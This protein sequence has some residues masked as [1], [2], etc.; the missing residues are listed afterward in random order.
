[1]NQV[2]R[3]PFILRPGSPGAAL[4][5]GCS[6]PE[7]SLNFLFIPSARG[8]IFSFI[9]LSGIIRK[10]TIF[11]LAWPRRKTDPFVYLTGVLLAGLSLSTAL[12]SR[13]L[14]L[15]GSD[16]LIRGKEDLIVLLLFLSIL[17]LL[18]HQ[19]RVLLIVG[20]TAGAMIL[21]SFA[22]L[23][24]PALAPG[25]PV[26]DFL[27][28]GGISANYCFDAGMLY[29]RHSLLALVPALALLFGLSRLPPG[30]V[31][32]MAW[33]LLSGFFINTLVALVQGFF[34]LNFLAA[35]SGTAVASGRATALLED[36]GAS[37]VYF[38]AMLSGLGALLLF[39]QMG[40]PVRLALL[41]LGLSGLAGG[42]QTGGRVFFVALVLTLML[43]TVFWI[44]VNLRQRMR[45]R[46]VV[47]VTAVLFSTILSVVVMAPSEIRT[48]SE[49][50]DSP[51]PG[52]VLNR[53]L[54]QMD[55]IRAVQIKT[56]VKSIMDHP[57]TGS[58]L[59]SFYARYYE[60]LEWALQGG[61]FEGVDVP[62]SFY[63]MVMAALGLAGLILLVLGLA[64]WFVVAATVIRRPGP[65]KPGWSYGNVN[66]FIFGLA[67]SLGVSLCI[68]VHILF[69]S[70]AFLFG[71][72]VAWFVREIYRYHRER[73]PARLAMGMA[74]MVP[75]LLLGA[76]IDPVLSPGRSPAFNWSLRHQPQ[77]PL[78]LLV[79]IRAPHK[80]HWIADRAELLLFTEE[81]E[82]FVAKPTE[83]FP[84]TVN[85]EILGHDQE[86]LEE[87]RWTVASWEPP[88]PGKNLTY[89]IG[90]K[91]R[92][93][94][95]ERIGPERFCSFR[96]TTHPTW[97][98]HGNNVA[99]FVRDI[100]T[101]FGRYYKGKTEVS[102]EQ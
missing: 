56:M 55:P 1:M 15:T 87:H 76:T 40:R 36:S 33:A 101:D 98:K 89:V 30:L 19:R 58:G 79:P 24:R 59:G 96:V 26:Q 92:K 54:V 11:K 20:M 9:R 99:A 90:E 77:V 32:I 27:F 64:G 43:I 93:T 10:R 83:Y 82:V 13:V 25:V 70:V 21:H 88:L 67:T 97:R 38:S 16:A 3:P 91:T 4:R 81:V 22:H 65:G 14:Q 8:K 18:V 86:V 44:L 57:V 73:W 42:M 49:M 5:K 74:V 17:I 61:G 34:D 37:T 53:V 29:L 23:F 60:N 41:L 72:T 95:L 63:L 47:L 100:Y 85:L 102:W 84:Q 52:G 45:L 35:G 66:A 46:S 6:L 71:L 94:C 7:Q 12:G 51:G 69:Q 50:M 78:S 39:G 75:L 68:G 2:G 28:P 48:G 80:G 31:R 62:G